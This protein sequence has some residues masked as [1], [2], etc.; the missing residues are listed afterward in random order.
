MNLFFL[1]RFVCHGLI[2]G[3]NYVFKVK[4]VN[5]AGYSQSSPNSD[6]VVVQAAIC[7][8]HNSF[9]LFTLPAVFSSFP[10]L[11]PLIHV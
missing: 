9:S 8:C 7:K 11:S 2:T 10:P 1:F 6:A 4:A 3:A 5:A